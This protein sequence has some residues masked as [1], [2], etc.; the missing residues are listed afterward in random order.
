MK[1]MSNKQVASR[2]EVE[3]FRR[4][5]SQSVAEGSHNQNLYMT[6][7]FGASESSSEIRQ[8]CQERDHLNFHGR[9]LERETL[10]CPSAVRFLEPQVA[11]IPPL[12]GMFEVKRKRRLLFR[13]KIFALD[14]KIYRSLIIWMGQEKMLPSCNLAALGFC[15]FLNPHSMREMKDTFSRAGVDTNGTTSA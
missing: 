1:S 12:I 13:Q 7:R 14:Q 11:H 9:N 5:L 6:S 4:E 15:I 10:A 8:L 2:E 3:H